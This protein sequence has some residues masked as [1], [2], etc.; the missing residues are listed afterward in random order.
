MLARLTLVLTV[1]L[2]A[3]SSSSAARAA[4]TSTPA[5]LKN[6]THLN[7][8]YHH[9][10]GEFGARDHTS[11]VPV[12]NFFHST[13]LYNKAMRYNRGLDRDKDGIACEKA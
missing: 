3:T 10:V 2:L 1:T 12:T 6:C 9:G 7:A 13:L 4:R 8:K 5:L 11:G